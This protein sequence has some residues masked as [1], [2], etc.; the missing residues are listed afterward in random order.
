M[1]SDREGRGEQDKSTPSVH[2]NLHSLPPAKHAA[3]RSCVVRSVV[4]DMKVGYLEVTTAT[5]LGVLECSVS[6]QPPEGR[7]FRILDGDFRTSDRFAPSTAKEM[8]LL[9]WGHV[10]LKLCYFVHHT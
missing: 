3:F 5:L 4:R 6:F 2:P 8:K 10:A 1:L 9:R 7:G